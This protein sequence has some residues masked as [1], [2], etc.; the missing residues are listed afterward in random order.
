[1]QSMNQTCEAEGCDRV[2][3][4][5]GLCRRHYARLHR[6]GQ[7]EARPWQP[8]SQCVVEGCENISESRGYCAMHRSR[9]RAHGEPGAPG[10]IKPGRKPAPKMPCAVEGCDRLRN[11]GAVYCHLHNERLRRTGETGPAQPTRTR[12][13]VKP[14]REGYRRLTLPDGRR[15]LEH[16]LVIERELGR[17]LA[18][19]ENVHHLNGVKDDNRP[20]NLELWVSM[21]PTGQRVEDV[22][23]WALEVLRRYEPGLLNWEEL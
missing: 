19:G 18:D 13:V 6:T 21:Q 9:M 16:V 1:M 8:K 23:A 15:M 4:A 22:V 20:E 17:R 2:V 11:H 3:A 12:G 5:R 7:L 10:H 14:T